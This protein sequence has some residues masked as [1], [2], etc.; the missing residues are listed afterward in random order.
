M[1]VTFLPS[2]FSLYIDI[3]VSSE[4]LNKFLFSKEHIPPTNLY[5]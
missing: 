5:E 2:L 3:L 4:R 1:A